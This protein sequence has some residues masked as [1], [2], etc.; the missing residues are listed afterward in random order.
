MLRDWLPSLR[1]R[2][3]LRPRFRPQL[4]QQRPRDPSV[5]REL[6]EDGGVARAKVVGRAAVSDVE[7]HDAV[8]GER[9]GKGAELWIGGRIDIYIDKYIDRWI[10]WDW[11]NDW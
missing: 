8:G 11:F 6:E 7:L 1:L 9:E 10:D 2:P 5:S 4:S 3:R